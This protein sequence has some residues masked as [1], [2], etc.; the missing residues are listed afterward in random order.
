MRGN[1]IISEFQRFFE[2]LLSKLNLFTQ[3]G[4]IAKM[5]K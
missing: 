4:S 5:G 1:I 3:N 2:N